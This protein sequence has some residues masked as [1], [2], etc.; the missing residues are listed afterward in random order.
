MP[1]VYRSCMGRARRWGRGFALVSLAESLAAGVFPM[2]CTGD[3]PTAT[4]GEAGAC[5]TG[6]EGCPCTPGGACDPGLECASSLCVRLTSDAAG[7]API[8]DASGD[9]A[10]DADAA[11][12]P[13]GKL[14]PTDGAAIYCPFQDAGG[15]TCAAPTQEC[16]VPSVGSS[17]CEATATA[18]PVDGSVVLECEDHQSCALG[19]ACCGAGTLATTD[20]GCIVGSGLTGTHCRTACNSDELPVCSAEAD[21]APGKTCTPFKVRGISL[22]VCL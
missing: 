2:A 8:G 19:H 16:C 17:T 20:A 10:S 6:T 18:C 15:T 5:A 22:G 1:L 3:D 11:A 9:G 12:S 13:C 7:D 21:C 4:S 14:F